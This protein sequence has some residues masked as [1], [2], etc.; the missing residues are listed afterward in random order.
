MAIYT[1]IFIFECVNHFVN[2]TPADQGVGGGAGGGGG[3]G[4]GGHG[5]TI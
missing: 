2:I 4:Q 1:S 5:P 3:G